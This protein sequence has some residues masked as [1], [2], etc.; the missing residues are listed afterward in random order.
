M[1]ELFGRLPRLG[2][3]SHFALGHVAGEATDIVLQDLVLV[4]ELVVV[5]LD[6]VNAFGEGL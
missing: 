5:R 6:G 3:A 1:G 4:L 2:T